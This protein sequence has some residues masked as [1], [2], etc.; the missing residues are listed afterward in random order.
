MRAHE[1]EF[2][3]KSVNLAAVGLGDRNYA[4]MFREDAGITFPL[5]IDEKRST[6]RAARLR[7]ANIFHLFKSENAAARERA[8]A[9]GHRQHQ[10][11]KDPL[12]LG[13]SFVFGPGNRDLFVHISRTF[14][15]NAMPEAW[16]AAIK[17]EIGA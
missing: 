6:Y 7:S 8:K 17:D 1:Q 14:G 12:Q 4:R 3:E 5:L 15:D 10:L 13:G 2:R 11:G 16:L 9:A